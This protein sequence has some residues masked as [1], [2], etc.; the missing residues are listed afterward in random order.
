[1]STG[2]TVSIS[3]VTL[4]Q[5]RSAIDNRGTLSVANAVFASNLTSGAIQTQGPLTVSNSTFSSNQSGTGGAIDITGTGSATVSNSSFTNNTAGYGGAIY[6]A[7]PSLT[8]T[9]CTFTNNQATSGSAT[10]QGGG[11]IH[12]NTSGTVWI[13][14]STFTGNDE[15]G[16]SGGGGAIRNRGGTWTIVNS[17]F[18]NNTAVDGGGAIQNAD[19][20]SITGSTITGN[21]ASGNAANSRGGAISAGGKLTI[22]N[23]LISGN[24]AAVDGGAIYYSAAFFSGEGHFLTITDSTI[25]TNTAGRN[26]GGLYQNQGPGPQVT[27]SRS[28]ISG[29][30][31]D[32]PGGG[33]GLGGGVW[34][35]GKLT[36]ENSTLSGNFADGNGGGIFD[37]YP[38]GGGGESLVIL[39][40]VTVVNNN[41]SAN[42]SDSTGGIYQSNSV[43]DAA[44]ILRN[45]IV[46]NNTGFGSPD[47]R[48][49]FNSQGYNLIENTTGANITGDTATNITGLDPNLGPLANNGG[50][51]FTHALLSGSPAI[52]QGHSFGTTTDQRGVTRP[53]D[54]PSI[55]NA[56]GGDGADIGAFELHPLQILSIT[57]SGSS[58]L[59]QGIGLPGATYEIQA[60]ENLL[61]GFDPDPIG[62]VTADVNG[63]FQFPDADATN[64]ARRFYRVVYP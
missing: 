63:N 41:G 22:A 35:R 57:K 24:S 16:G 21:T 19:V 33:G 2:D 38:G 39:S 40:G 36:M 58:V 32:V 53:T 50:P 29:N 45:T 43:G 60:T 31:A 59:L 62:S 61:Q 30:S 9:G 54:Q 49:T 42:S 20:M 28:T 48:N 6:T 46:A 25:S 51:T 13:S 15:V 1:V 18:T 56:A 27:I 52:D 55:A 44:I 11:A 37:S 34:T 5:G 23:T 7:G 3:G 4:T 12:S 14:D 10:P 17:A 26:G 8:V 64:L 47:V